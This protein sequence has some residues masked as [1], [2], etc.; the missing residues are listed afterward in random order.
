VARHAEEGLLLALAG[1][2][3]AAVPWSGR[4][5]GVH[6]SRANA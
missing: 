6:V 1:Q 4:T 5:P 2:L 3:A